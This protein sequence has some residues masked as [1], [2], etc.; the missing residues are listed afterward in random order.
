[1]ARIAYVNGKYE[2]HLDATIHIED[3]G[4]QFADGVYEVIAVI[5]NKFIGEQGHLDRLT[6]SLQELRIDWPVSR[7]ALKVIINE[8][9]RRNAVDHGLVYLQITRGAAPRDHAFPNSSNSALVVTAKKTAPLSE[10]AFVRGINV[11]TIPDIRWKRCDI[12]SVALRPNVL[13]KQQAREAG[14][15][16]AWQVDSDGFVTEGTST[17]AWIVTPDGAL[18]TR[19]AST[20]ILNG[21]T[22]LAVL[23]AATSAG[24]SI[25]E[26]SFTP[27]EAILAREA[28]ITS[29]TSHV[30]AVTKIDGHDIGNGNVG[31][32]TRQILNA[33]MHYVKTSGG[34]KSTNTWK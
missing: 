22:R 14:A 21:I 16:E 31:D 25:I 15:F 26:R 13:G 7:S 10:E 12:K 19:S 32:L 1:M 20:F 34:P 3:R 23:E 5:D 28:F 33:Y 27:S 11:I 17:N 29:S 24:V 8:V 6:H 30:K 18:I 9:K 4:Y 2:R